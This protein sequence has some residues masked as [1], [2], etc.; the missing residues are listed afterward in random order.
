MNA[1]RALEALRKRI[2]PA[3]MAALVL[4]AMTAL[5]QAIWVS[6]LE[7]RVQR[8]QSRL[9][10]RPGSDPAL[11]RTSSAPAAA[12]RSTAAKLDAFHGFFERPESTTDRLAQIYSI[13]TKTGLELASAEYRMEPAGSQLERLVVS[14]PLKG[15]SAQVRAF[16]ENCLNDIPVV[17]VERVVF[18]RKRASDTLVDAE[19]ELS[20]YR[21]RP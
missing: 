5:F 18:R 13:A 3:G 19:V 9:N 4:I 1:R 7:E 10:A 16:I 12:A 11:I 2:G 8:L 21:V 6:P 20:V 17:A 14:L 15:N